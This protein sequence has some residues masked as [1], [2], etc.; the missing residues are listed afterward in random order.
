MN[1][2]REEIRSPKLL[3]A[4]VSRERKENQGG[5]FEIKDPTEKYTRL[6]DIVFQSSFEPNIK[7][8]LKRLLKEFL[9]LFPQVS[10]VGYH[11]RAVEETIDILSPVM[12]DLKDGKIDENF[13]EQLAF[14]D[15]TRLF[16]LVSQLGFFKEIYV[17]Q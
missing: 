17:E 11:I 16:K 7:V 3:T 10:G 6:M 1:K 15:S 14:N 12:K 9:G 2:R 8:A 4:P 13:G 5:A